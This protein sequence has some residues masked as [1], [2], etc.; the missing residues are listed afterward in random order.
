MSHQHGHGHDNGH[1]AH[2]RV[3]D[4]DARV[5]GAQLD[6]VLDLLGAFE[7]TRVADLGAGTGTGT[8]LLGRRFP[9]AEVIAVDNSPT[10]L[11][12]LR[13]EGFAVLAADLAD[14]FPPVGDVD[15]VWMS[16]SLHHVSDPAG[17]LAGAR[18][19]TVLIVE[20]DGLPQ[21]LGTPLEERAHAAAAADGWNHHDDWTPVLEAAGFAVERHT[22]T[23]EPPADDLAHEYARA[24]LPRFLNVPGFSSQNREELSALLH[25]EFVVRPRA[26][27]SVWIGKAS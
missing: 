4:L 1:D 18:A 15:L 24:W 22:V 20:V 21:F 25:G 12:R 14:G 6:A 17:L 27:R 2:Q 8:R 13:A 3:L 10:M 19:A 16:S 11:D 7:P 9:A 26:V 5:F 23:L